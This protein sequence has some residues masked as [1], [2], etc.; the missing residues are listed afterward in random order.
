MLARL[1]AFT[2]A[3]R[4]GQRSAD[5]KQQRLRCVLVHAH[6]LGD[7]ADPKV[8]EVTKDDRVALPR[9]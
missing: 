1:L 5:S 6:R 8:D 2:N 9:G 4:G 3:E 7:L